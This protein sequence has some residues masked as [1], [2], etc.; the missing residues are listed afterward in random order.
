MTRK[1]AKQSIGGI[2]AWP[3]MDAR[4]DPISVILEEFGSNN[5]AKISYSVQYHKERFTAYKPLVVLSQIA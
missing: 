3:E 4:I 1:Q 2:V 5:M